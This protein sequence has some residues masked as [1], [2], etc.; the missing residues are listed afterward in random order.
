MG[1][2]P[3]RR[4]PPAR[5]D[6]AFHRGRRTGC[7]RRRRPGAATVRARSRAHPARGRS[8]WP[9]GLRRPRRARG[10]DAQA[11]NAARRPLAGHRRAAC[12]RSRDGRSRRGSRSGR[13]RLRCRRGRRDATGSGP[14]RSTHR[15]AHRRRV[16]VAHACRSGSAGQTRARAFAAPSGG[17]VAAGAPPRHRTRGAV[18]ASPILDL[19]ADRA[20]ADDKAG[21]MIDGSQLPEP[22][23]VDLDIVGERYRADL[24]RVVLD[25]PEGRIHSPIFARRADPEP[26]PA[27]VLPGVELPSIRSFLGP[28]AWV[29]VLGL[30]VLAPG[31]LASRSR[32]G[33]LRPDRSRGA[34]AGGSL[35][36]LLRR[37]LPR[38]QGPGWMAAGS[39]GGRRR[40]LELEAGPIGSA[41]TGRARLIAA[42][43]A[44][45]NGRDL[46]GSQR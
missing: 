32:D 23:T 43:S 39:P 16:G 13:L 25:R 37:G 11:A 34:P 35:D 42:N 45:A 29:L 31:R 28:L 5:F 19:D 27:D 40:A 38:V 46:P 3:C 36:D 22:A 24:S 8:G 6:P 33:R 7:R 21:T 1:C 15:G 10:R 26:A 14:S 4:D 41:G 30:P 20:D 9:A 17:C 12:P 2:R 18:A 44:Q